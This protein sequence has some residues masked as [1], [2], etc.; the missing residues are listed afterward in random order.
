MFPHHL[1]VTKI[2]YTIPRVLMITVGI[3]RREIPTRDHSGDARHRRLV[4]S[5][6]CSVEI[7][8]NSLKGSTMYVQ[9]KQ[10]QVPTLTRSDSLPHL[11]NLTQAGSMRVQ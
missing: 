7:G 4:V 10:Y 5:V 2:L 3:S 1:S 6:V 8:I 11:R 9:T